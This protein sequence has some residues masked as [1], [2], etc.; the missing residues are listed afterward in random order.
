MTATLAP[1]LSLLVGVFLLL[2]GNGLL[3]SLLAVRLDL[4]GVGSSWIGAVMG[5]YFLG[6]LL[7]AR[8][9]QPTVRAV[10]HI[11]AF[12]AFAALMTVAVL[13]HGLFVSVWLWGLLRFMGGFAMAALF[14]VIESW[15]NVRAT[16]ETRGSLLALYMVTSNAGLAMGQVL[17]GK[18]DPMLLALFMVAALFFAAALV[19]LSLTRA[20]APSLPTPQPLP[21]RQ[22]IRRAPLGVVGTLI[23][24]MLLSAFYTLGPVFGSSLGWELNELTRWMTLVILGGVLLQ[25][26]LGLLSDRIGREKV[27]LGVCLALS[28][29]GVFLWLAM[30]G[31]LHLRLLAG[32]LWGGAAFMVYP[33]SVAQVN[34]WIEDDE[35]VAAAGQLLLVYGVGAAVH[36]LLVGMLM[37]IGGPGLWPLQATFFALVLTGVHMWRETTRETLPLAQQEEF[38][39]MM[40]TSAALVHMDPRLEP[41]QLPLPLHYEDA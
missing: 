34:D 1:I 6:M 12:A 29:T 18:G 9:A 20:E 15:L 23:S 27:Y 14:L 16:P 13:L 2:V 36:P 41:Q 32:A 17:L 35:R 31:S 19:P 21:L 25:W 4:E 24:G 26:P 7:G 30:E 40:R 22:L 38:V 11:R 28:A 37:D 5:L 33:L 3:T 8:W 10:G 39:P